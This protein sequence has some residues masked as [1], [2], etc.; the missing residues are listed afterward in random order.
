MEYHFYKLLCYIFMSL[1]L[2]IANDNE[3]FN[4]AGLEWDGR[5]ESLAGL[6][7]EV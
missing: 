5:I 6:L 1:L 7:C 2:Q 4:S 3:R